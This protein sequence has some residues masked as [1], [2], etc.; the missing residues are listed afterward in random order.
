MWTRNR[1][2][3]KQATTDTTAQLRITWRAIVTT[4][5]G[6]NYDTVKA[7]AEFASSTGL[8][9]ST[10]PWYQAAIWSYNQK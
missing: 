10:G 4:A 2:A 3:A 8:S 9:L 1:K 7:A 6:A 5:T